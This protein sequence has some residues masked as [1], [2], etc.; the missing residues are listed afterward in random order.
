MS[1][2]GGGGGVDIMD[3]FW[4]APPVTRSVLLGIVIVVFSDMTQFDCGSNVRGVC[5]R[6]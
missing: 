3:R 1:G 2:N 4:S 6:A 5:T